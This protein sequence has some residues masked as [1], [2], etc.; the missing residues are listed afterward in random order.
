M[1]GSNDIGTF[2]TSNDSLKL[3]KK[4]ALEAARNLHY[5]PEVIDKIKKCKSM[6]QISIVMTTAR[7]TYL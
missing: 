7:Q 2:L 4:Q 3:Y 6:G 5:P 1:T